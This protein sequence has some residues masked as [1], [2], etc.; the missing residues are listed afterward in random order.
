MGTLLRRSFGIISLFL[1]ALALS[2]HALLSI[3]IREAVRWRWGYSLAFEQLSIAKGGF[4]LEKV[5]LSSDAPFELSVE[6]AF[7]SVSWNRAVSLSLHHPHLVFVEG[8]PSYQISRDK[9]IGGLSITI[10]DGTFE[11]GGVHPLSGNFSFQDKHLQLEGGGGCLSFTFFGEGEQRWIECNMEKWPLAPLSPILQRFDVEPLSGYLSGSLHLLEHQTLGHLSLQDASWISKPWQAA[12]GVGHLEWEGEANIGLSALRTK[13]IDLSKLCRFKLEVQN[14]FALRNASRVESVEGVLFFNEGVGLRWELEGK[15][16]SWHGKSFFRQG[17]SEWLQSRLQLL[18]ATIELG[19]EKTGG[20]RLWNL[21]LE[22]VDAGLFHWICDFGPSLEWPCKLKKGELNAHV[23][24]R[25]HFG[26]IIEWEARDCKGAHLAL[27]F[28]DW[29][30]SCNQLAASARCQENERSRFCGQ[31]ALEEGS[32]IGKNFSLANLQTKIC[33]HQG[34]IQEGVA[35]ANCQ[36]LAGR[37]HFTGSLN[38]ISAKIDIQGPWSDL[39]K[40][41]GLSVHSP[42]E[43]LIE[44]TLLL[45]GDWNTSSGSFSIPFSEG[46]ILSATF[47]L[48]KGQICQAK[49]E[50]RQFELSRLEPFWRGASQGILNLLLFYEDAKWSLA[51]GGEDLFLSWKESQAWIPSF[52]VSGVCEDGNWKAETQK[53]FGEV[54]LLGEAIPFAGKLGFEEGLLSFGIAEANVLGVF[55]SGEC[56]FALTEP[57]IPFLFEVSSLQGDIAELARYSGI[58]L[59]GK[60]ASG[61]NCCSLDGALFSNPASWHWRLSANFSEISMGALHRAQAFLSAD[62]DIGLLDCRDL[63]GF[64][65]VGQAQFPVRGF[66]EYRE[67]SWCF[68]LRL[69]DRWRDLARVAGKILCESQRSLLE[70]DGKKSHLL[71]TPIHVQDC[72]IAK[73]RLE[74]IKVAANFSCDAL[75]T[76]RS[77]LAEIDQRIATLLDAPLQGAFAVDLDLRLAALSFVRIDGEEMSWNGQPIPLHLAL[78]LSQGKWKV[79]ALQA[80]DLKGEAS[81]TRAEEGWKI[82]GGQISFGEGIEAAFSGL[83]SSE[84]QCELAVDTLRMDAQKAPWQEARHLQGALSGKGSVSLGWQEELAFEADFDLC[85]SAF[86]VGSL[87]VENA[88]ALQVHLSKRQG[89]QGLLVRG[90]DLRIKKPESDSLWLYGRIGLMQYDFSECRFHLHHSHLK[91][92]AD[93]LPFLFEQLGANHPLARGFALLDAKSDLECFAEFSFLEDLSQLSCSMKEGFVPFCGAIRHLQNVDFRYGG[94]EAH[95]E[96]LAL[97]QGRNLKVGTFVEIDRL[98]GLLTLEDEGIKLADGERPM[99]LQWELHPKKG[100]L[101][102]SI[103]G[104]FGGIEASFHEEVYEEGASLIGTAKLDFGYLA[105]LLEPRIARPFHELKM[106]KGYELKG[107]F[108]YGSDWSQ[109]QFKGLLSGKNCELFGWQIRSLLSQV[110]IDPELI[111]IFEVKGSDSAGILKIDSLT[112]SH[113]EAEPWKIS[114]PS[115]KLF[116]FRPSL[117]QKIGREAGPVGPLVLRELSMKDFKGELDESLTYTAQGSL[118]FINSFKREHTVFD[119]PSDVLGR[120]FGLD[121][122]L[123]I[124]VQGNLKFELK[125]GKFWLDELEDAYSEGQR[126]KFFLVKEGSSPTIDL[127]GNVSI[128]V[129]MKQYVLFKFTENFLLS[130]EGTLENPS[131]SLQKK[132]RIQKLLEL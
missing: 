66:A 125:E 65:H 71:G 40:C 37:A 97:H 21:A 85:A 56:L 16:F 64:I 111:R 51:A 63:K 41:A 94:N 17:D 43:A 30:F 67:N 38:E 84:M 83:L 106:G 74:A 127:D 102:H 88:G 18:E 36:G 42:S 87:N 6:K 4:V 44:G 28:E 10:Q 115:F 100:L 75:R 114:M 128:L 103:E 13:E 69:E 79:E 122:E 46:E 33:I 52:Y 78:L 126:S 45:K 89:L 121:L 109:A 96:F 35:Q 117:L 68:D 9:R 92:P 77:S 132:S 81:F 27:S 73:Q 34:E 90:L 50:T 47:S 62:S 22:K 123:L 101:L 12:G 107:R 26:E 60:I 20:E 54:A 2:W 86:K 72:R 104:T 112:I 24:C 25:E 80:G 39:G 7:F 23:F 58:D 110:E 8:I 76:W 91:L 49:I 99:E 131:Y 15:E 70:L 124:P 14:L 98:A 93:S 57:D 118:S 105:Q 11:L 19:M 32:L 82:E 129:K 130:I 48:N 119:L 108:F 113:S 59:Q 55:V 61:A 29:N 1:L 3:A 31:V 53:L 120:I 116:E 5:H 95:L